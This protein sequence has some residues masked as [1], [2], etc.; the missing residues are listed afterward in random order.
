MTRARRPRLA[1]CASTDWGFPAA[2]F[3]SVTEPSGSVLA[4]S[5]IIVILA[6]H[7]A[8]LTGDEL[9][10]ELYHADA[11]TSTIRAELA[12]LR[13]LLGAESIGS[14]RLRPCAQPECDWLAVTAYL[15]AG[16]VREAVRA[17]RGPLL[18]RSDA[19]GVVTRRMRLEREL[20]AAVL[21]SG[22]TDLLVS[23]TRTPWGA[24]DLPVWERQVSALPGRS[25][26]A[27]MARA[28]A[29]HLHHEFAAD[30][31]G[32]GATPLPAASEAIS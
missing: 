21:A 8:G 27:N 13:A 2:R 15:A 19:P 16:R 9:A 22:D 3:R 7:P 10:V 6:D 31:T 25:P 29:R 18:P 30:A 28:E 32:G 12:R 5:E 1:G 4:H 23:W 17:Y 26:L 14:R 24:D 11:P 20:R